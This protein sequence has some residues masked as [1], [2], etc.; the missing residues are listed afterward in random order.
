MSGFVND[1]RIKAM[2][3]YSKPIVAA[4]F[5][6]IFATWFSHNVKSDLPLI[7]Q[8]DLHAHDESSNSVVSANLTRQFFPPKVR[9]NPLTQQQGNWMEGPY[10]QHI[11]PL[12][13]YVPYL[14]FQI[15][16]QITIEVKRLAYAFITLLT[17]LFFI[18]IV[19]RYSK[20]LLAS[21]A[22]SI[23]AIFWINT[24]FT[25]ELITGYA[26]G[27]SD[28]V[29]AFASV[30]ALGGLLDYLS[31]GKRLILTAFFVALPI[32]AKSLLGAI[33]AAAFLVI[34][35]L[36]NKKFTRQ[37]WK[38][39]GWLAVFL[40]IY[41]LPLFISSPTTFKNEIIVPFLH[42]GNYEGW[43]RPWHFYLTDYLP[44]RYLF[45]WTWWYFLGL[46]LAI[47]I[48]IKYLVYKDKKIQTMLWLSLGWFV[49]NLTAVSLVSS[50]TPNFIY[51]SYLFSLFAITLALLSWFD[52]WR[53][54][55]LDSKIL[56]YSLAAVLLIAILFTGRSYWRF[57]NLFQAQRTSAYNY[58]TEPEKFY[59]VGEWMQKFGVNQRDLTVVRVS[60]N[61]CW[62]RYYIL[63]LSG[64]ESKTLLEMNFLPREYGAQVKQK[65]ARIFL[66]V[67]KSEPV[68]IGLPPYQRTQLDNYSIIG[69]D[70]NNLSDIQVR[71]LISAF[72]QA[73]ANDIAA[74]I[75]RI[76]ADKT[77]CQWLVPDAILNAP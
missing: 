24:P 49:A 61:D 6:L 14:F 68:P 5:M 10:W 34:L 36:E 37:F 76:K 19:Y 42:G 69:F 33:P 3:K 18:W 77:S 44:Q 60:D 23:A 26:F 39:L 25:H 40:V 50:K 28:I 47:G 8:K 63:F 43:G 58:L 57:V 15:D 55:Q 64:A 20:N 32:M 73:H 1:D 31:S 67:N 27:A 75:L 41:Y 30:L 11:P 13:A 48:S 22:A 56:K 53:L 16:G 21:A 66:V 62:L 45:G 59:E 72:V 35:F 46:I 4:I 51:Q 70:M 9:V 71:D 65:Y 17:G 12:F 7:F 2:N 52:R 29:L 54:E 38:G 74:D